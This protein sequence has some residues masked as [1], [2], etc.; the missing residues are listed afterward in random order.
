MHFPIRRLLGLTFDTIIILQYLGN[1]F[2]LSSGSDHHLKLLKQE[3]C[4]W[5]QEN[6]CW[7]QPGGAAAKCPC[8]ASAAWGLLVWVPGADMAPLGK[9]CCGRR[10]MYKAEEDGHRS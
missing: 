7:G 4:F 1:F 9:P 8:S 2:G 3:I 6:E 10:P 5:G